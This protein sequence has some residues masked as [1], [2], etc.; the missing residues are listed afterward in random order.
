MRDWEDVDE[1]RARLLTDEV[2]QLFGCP[3]DWKA[4][5]GFD[6]N[7]NDALDAL[8]GEWVR[9]VREFSVSRREANVAASRREA[10]V[11]AWVHDE[12]SDPHTDVEELKSLAINMAACRE[13]AVALY[14]NGIGCLDGLQFR[15]PSF[16]GKHYSSAPFAARIRK[17]KSQF[18]IDL[19]PDTLS[20][21][22]WDWFNDVFALDDMRVEG[23]TDEPLRFPYHTEELWKRFLMHHHVR[24]AMNTTAAIGFLGDQWLK[25]I[26]IDLNLDTRTAHE[27]PVS[28]EEAEEI[29]R[30]FGVRPIKSK[31][32]DCPWN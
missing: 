1:V 31:E 7:Q 25:H 17:K 14:R 8:H 18:F 16:N 29:M 28:E 10:N 23:A 9:C 5:L 6:P 19:R 20:S 30:P 32:Y 4:N 11:A 24:V 3:T 12:F 15:S 26:A 13:R 21:L 22:F 2:R 27:F